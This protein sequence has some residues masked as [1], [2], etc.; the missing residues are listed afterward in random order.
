MLISED[1]KRLNRQLHEARL[2]YGA[3]GYASAEAVERAM[4]MHGCA[5]MLDYGCGKGA[6]MNAVAMLNPDIEVAGY[7]PAIDGLEADPQP[8]DLVACL[9]VLEHIEPDCLDAVLRHIAS[10]MRKAGYLTISLQL[11]EKTL[12]DGRNAHLI[13]ESPEWW[14]A[15][16]FALFHVRWFHNREDREMSVVV[17]PKEA[18]AWPTW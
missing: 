16:L 14:L 2:D 4:Q 10:K 15:K 13:V 17:E 8:A 5:S 18:F 11:A 6:L 12:A 1:Y 9:D 3:R 7:D